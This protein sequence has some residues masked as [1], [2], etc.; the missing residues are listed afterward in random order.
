MKRAALIV[1][2]D[3]TDRSAVVQDH[4]ASRV[5]VDR[6]RILVVDALGDRRRC[7]SGFGGRDTPM[8]QH[9]LLD[10]PQAPDLLRIWTLA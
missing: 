7:L 10:S 8:I 5:D 9:R 3:A 4:I 2:E 6:R 1:V